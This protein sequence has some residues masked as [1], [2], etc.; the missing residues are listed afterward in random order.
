MAKQKQYAAFGALLTEAIKNL[1][2]TRRQRVG[3]VQQDL[4]NRLG[5]SVDAIYVW[6]RGEYLPDDPEV[7]ALLARAFVAGWEA[8]RQWVTQFLEKGEYFDHGALVQELFGETV[9]PTAA[10][11]RPPAEV[12]TFSPVWFSPR[13]YS[14]SEIRDTGTGTLVVDCERV[15]FS[16]SKGNVII[17]GIPRV[18]HTRMAGDLADAWVEVVYA[19]G[20]IAYFA[21]ASRAGLVTLLGGSHEIFAALARCVS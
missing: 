15:E 4:A 6:R 14:F 13:K 21:D 10:T 11:N 17:T 12:Q 9:A 5:Y 20:Q 16:W 1:A 2:R 8:D 18:T 19:G 3:P 7:V